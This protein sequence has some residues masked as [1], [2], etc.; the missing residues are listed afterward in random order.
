VGAD[1]RGAE[2]GDL[3]EENRDRWAHAET[4]VSD[5]WGHKD[6]RADW[7]WNTEKGVTWAGSAHRF[8]RHREF[9]P[10]RR[11]AFFFFHTNF[12]IHWSENKPG[13]NT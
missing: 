10:R 7:Q 2:D 13:K 11:N 1:A 4:M 5:R 6:A 9:S 12:Q 3:G 8:H